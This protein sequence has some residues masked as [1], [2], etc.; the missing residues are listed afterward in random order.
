MPGGNIPGTG[1][2]GGIP[3]EDI[4]VFRESEIIPLINAAPIDY[5]EES[6][7]L[8]EQGSV[9]M[10]LYFDKLGTL[11]DSKITR[12]SGFKRLDDAAR[13]SVRNM[14]FRAMGFSFIYQTNFDFELEK[15]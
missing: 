1:A 10:D 4:K 14:Q 9:R 7:K 5:P 8:R 2:P 15:N 11:I 3:S 13:E 6:I 12:S